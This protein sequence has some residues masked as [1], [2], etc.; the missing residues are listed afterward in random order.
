MATKLKYNVRPSSLKERQQKNQ[1]AS[2]VDMVRN[3]NYD[4]EM[5]KKNYENNLAQS[6][7]N[8]Q[9]QN[10]PPP[11]PTDPAMLAEYN[12]F[13]ANQNPQT[14]MQFGKPYPVAPIRPSEQGQF[15]QGRLM[16][17]S[18][19][20]GNNVQLD[21]EPIPPFIPKGMGGSV[22]YGQEPIP[23]VIS[24]PAMQQFQIDDYNNLL[25]QG[26]QNSNTMN[27]NGMANFA[28]IQP[29][30]PLADRGM[31]K[32]SPAPRRFSISN[33]PSAKAF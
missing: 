27:Q 3:P 23:P 15:T 29:G 20:M 7:S 12:K 25:R 13:M 5:A 16:A 2:V 10:N 33:N 21:Q 28:N 32:S 18:G 14:R 31:Q 8:S 1:T 17:P 9:L 30:M 24:R 6:I 11:P 26:I 22:Q 4:I 19:G